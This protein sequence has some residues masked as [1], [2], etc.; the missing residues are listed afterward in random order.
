MADGSATEYIGA[1]FGGI[2]LLISTASAYYAK[3]AY[4][5][6]EETKTTDLRIELRKSGWNPSIS[7]MN[8]TSF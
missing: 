6:A 1:I 4:T 8:L 2:S 7:Q 3:K 5:I